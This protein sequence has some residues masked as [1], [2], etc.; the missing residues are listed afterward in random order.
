MKNI[1]W[2]GVFIL[3]VVCVI[4]TACAGNL[5]VSPTS[6]SAATGS[7]DLS[8]SQVAGTWILT[9]IQP[10]KG[11]VQTV[12]AIGSYTLTFADQRMSTKADCNMCNG[13]VTY[14]GGALTISPLL[15]CTRAACPSMAFESAYESILGG[16]SASSVEGHTL[17]LA[18]ER[19]RATFVR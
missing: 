18:S 11:A 14:S 12:P 8:A 4:S 16:A 1:T 9:S 17:V 15:A 19:G 13:G 5:P 6:P 3:S 2:G 7:M 10:D